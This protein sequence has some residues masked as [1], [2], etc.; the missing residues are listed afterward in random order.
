[1]VRPLAEDALDEVSILV[2]LDLALQRDSST[3]GSTSGSFQSL[4]YWI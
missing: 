4:L 3:S 2:V 1:M